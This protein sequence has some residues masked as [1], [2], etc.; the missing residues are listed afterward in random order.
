MKKLLIIDRV[1]LLVVTVIL[2]VNAFADIE[3][4]SIIL[5]V[6]ATYLAISSIVG[7]FFALKNS[8]LRN[9]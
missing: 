1:L 9:K 8:Y 2:A 5:Y 6:C 3:V 7:L 4:A